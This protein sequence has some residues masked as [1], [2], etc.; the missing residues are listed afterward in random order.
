MEGIN[1]HECTYGF[2]KMLNIANTLNHMSTIEYGK[3][4]LASKKQHNKMDNV[5]E[6]LHKLQAGEEQRNLSNYNLISNNAS[7]IAALQERLKS[8]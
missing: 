3:N 2:D 5:W 8:A 7:V 6:S 1:G 4:G